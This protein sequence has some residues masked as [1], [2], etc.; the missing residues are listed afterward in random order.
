MEK[1][2][3]YKGL[4][5]V[6][7]VLVVV[8]GALCLLFATGTISLKGD[9][10]QVPVENNANNNETSNVSQTEEDSLPEWAEY[11]L[12][13]NI[14]QIAVYNRNV[15]KTFEPGDSCPDPEYL[16]NGQFKSVL[17]E[18]VKFK[19]SK[20][21]DASGFGGVCMKRIIVTYDGTKKF[22]LL[23]N[24]YIITDDSKIESLLEKEN[25][26]E[27]SSMKGKETNKDMF[28]YEWDESYL[29]NLLG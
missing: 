21:V 14:S 24:K 16:T 12:T 17:K 10:P 2:K 27:N 6:L 13:H 5:V 19:L 7:F 20:Y 1:E 11:L 28:A 4:I 18:M 23:L 9:E 22:E 25:Y 26:T 3:S 8:L 29:D 15:P